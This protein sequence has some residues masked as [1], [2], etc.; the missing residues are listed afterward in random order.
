ELLGGRWDFAKDSFLVIRDFPILGGGL[1][2]YLYHLRGHNYL[3]LE[4]VHTV[5]LLIMA[6]TGIIG[7]LF[8]VGL[9]LANCVTAFQGFRSR[10]PLLRCLS[11]GVLGGMIGFIGDGFANFSY[12]MLHILYLFWFLSGLIAA[13]AR[14]NQSVQSAPVLELVERLR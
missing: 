4:L 8:F 3:Y 11:I 9:V 10:D 5:Y 12:I 2:N 13:A 1:N 14:L 7:L 6:E